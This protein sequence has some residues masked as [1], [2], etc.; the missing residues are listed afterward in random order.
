MFLL[1]KTG[2]LIILQKTG[3]NCENEYC[4]VLTGQYGGKFS[5]SSEEAYEAKW[6]DAND[7]L[8]DIKENPNK[9]TP[10]SVKAIKFLRKNI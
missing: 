9:Y 5:P 4:A 1:K 7:F 10:W 8:I 2:D 3:K 6:I